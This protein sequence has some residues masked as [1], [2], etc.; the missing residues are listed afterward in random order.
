MIF[1]RFM[2]WLATLTS[3][4]K[5]SY[6]TRVKRS[7]VRKGFAYTVAELPIS[8]NFFVR[9]VKQETELSPDNNPWR[10]HSM[11]NVLVWSQ[12]VAYLYDRKRWKR[13][14]RYIPPTQSF[15]CALD[16]KATGG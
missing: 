15:L 10:K 8:I 1:E 6:R 12:Y 5:P 16:G 9:L 7:V 13:R 4:S 3:S 14:T 2:K 11:V